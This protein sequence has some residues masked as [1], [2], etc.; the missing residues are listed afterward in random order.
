MKLIK[1][2]NAVSKSCPLQVCF[3]FLFYHSSHNLVY[4]SIDFSWVAVSKSC[5]LQ[6]FC[7]LKFLNCSFQTLSTAMCV[8]VQRVSVELAVSKP[9]PLQVC[10]LFKSLSCSFQ[11]LST[12]M[13]VCVQS[14]SVELAVSKPCPLQVFCLFRCLSCSFQ[15]LSTA[16]LI[17]ISSCQLKLQFYQILFKS[18]DG[19]SQTILKLLK[20]KWFSKYFTDFTRIR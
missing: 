9:C 10:C 16:T 6:V 12:A 3:D 11:T 20:S 19:G 18:Q 15:T 2:S 13:C 17:C 1:I 4:W 7:L 14:V 8:C 5:P